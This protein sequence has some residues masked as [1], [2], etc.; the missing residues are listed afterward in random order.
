MA[1][2]HEDRRES[3]SM[4]IVYTYIVGD[5]LHFGHLRYL[6]NA[7]VLGDILVAGVLTDEA[8]MEK[9]PR[10]IIPFAERLALIGALECVDLAVPQYTYSPYDNVKN[11]GAD[12][13]V[14]STS[15]SEKLISYG[16][17]LMESL[18]GRLV[19]L[20]YYQGQSSSKIK[21]EIKHE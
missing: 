6:L 19:V 7:K 1:E 12:I 9:K 10:P 4:I 20:P 8:V 13:L 21:E 2:D 15:H 18:D 16:R 11:V 14:E 17:S 5:I 3:N